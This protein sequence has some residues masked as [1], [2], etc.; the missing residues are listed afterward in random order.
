MEKAIVA[1]GHKLLVGN[2][3]RPQMTRG[4]NAWAKPGRPVD[5]RECYED[6]EGD[7]CMME[8]KA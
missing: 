4:A 1:L 2:P 8:A 3:A 5:L 6:G 7:L